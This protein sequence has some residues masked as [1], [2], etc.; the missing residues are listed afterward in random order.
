MHSVYSLAVLTARQRVQSTCVGLIT[1]LQSS[2]IHWDHQ[3]LPWWRSHEKESETAHQQGL[4]DEKTWR[5]GGV[6]EG[7]PTLCCSW[8]CEM[9]A[10]VQHSYTQFISQFL[11]LRGALLNQTASALV[12]DGWLVCTW[13]GSLSH[14]NS[15]F[16]SFYITLRGLMKLIKGSLTTFVSFEQL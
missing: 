10:H 15:S 12:F 3:A 9:K 8:P 11:P 14:P 13:D 4:E 7:R 1:S 6:R 5:S 16:I 2:T